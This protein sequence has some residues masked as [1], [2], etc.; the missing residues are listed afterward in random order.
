MVFGILKLLSMISVKGCHHNVNY[1]QKY[2]N[3]SVLLVGDFSAVQIDPLPVLGINFEA[4]QATAHM[5]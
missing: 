3:N 1:L 5:I 4:N 2:K